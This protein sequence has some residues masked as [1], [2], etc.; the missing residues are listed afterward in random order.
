M[1]IEKN[2]ACRHVYDWKAVTIGLI[3][4]LCVL[5]SPFALAES[6]FKPT[7]AAQYQ[8]LSNLYGLPGGIARATPSGQQTRGD[9]AL[10]LS[11]RFVEDIDFGRQDFTLDV[12]FG[13]LTYV[14]FT[15]LD[16]N[17]YNADA[18]LKWKAGRIFDGTLGYSQ[19]QSMV[20]FNELDNPQAAPTSILLETS[21]TGSMNVNVDVTPI[22]RLESGAVLRNLNSPRPG[23][24]NLVLD[25]NTYKLAL[26][27][28]SRAHLSFG[29]DTTFVDGKYQK[30]LLGQNPDYKQAS[31]QLAADYVVSGLSAFSAAAG[32]TKRTQQGGNIGGTN[33]D[34]SAVTGKLGYNRKITAK[35]SIDIQI[36]RAV[37]SYVSTISSEIDSSANLAL[38]WQA[39]AKIISELHY[40][41]I[42]SDFP[43]ELVPTTTATRLDHSQ[44]VSFELKYQML[45][46]VSLKPYVRYED[47]ASNIPVLQYNGKTIG[48]QLT[49]SWQ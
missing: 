1:T 47:R 32:Y 25:E 2:E 33:G 6:Q 46:T 29:L 40:G 19:E 5:M 36:Q 49:G 34:V 48:I 22:W 37:N 4:S 39:T 27:N 28:V 35:T 18:I 41:W 15:Q 16:H 17:E 13:H 43:N 20:S 12:R 10:D 30:S 7:V 44:F 31:Y 42:N 8:Y 3:G 26:R 21:K 9:H 11:A 24:P 14:L 45:R 23:Y 38:S